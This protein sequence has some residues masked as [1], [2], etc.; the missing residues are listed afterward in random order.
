MAINDLPN[1]IVRKHMY[2]VATESPNLDIV[3]GVDGESQIYDMTWPCPNLVLSW[4][5]SLSL[6]SSFVVA[7]LASRGINNMPVMHV[8]TLGEFMLLCL[9]FAK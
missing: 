7:M 9:F 4:Y 5:L 1:A 6:A 3:Q 8:Y 2:V